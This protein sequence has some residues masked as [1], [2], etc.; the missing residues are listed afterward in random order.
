MLS[1]GCLER[2]END[3]EKNEEFTRWIVIFVC[4]SCANIVI[5][6][7]CLDGNDDTVRHWVNIALTYLPGCKIWLGV[8]EDQM[9][10]SLQIAN[11]ECIR[12]RKYITVQNKAK[13]CS[14]TAKRVYKEEIS[15]DGKSWYKGWW[16]SS[17]RD[18]YGEAKFPSGGSYKGEWRDGA[19]EGCG[20]RKYASGKI[21]YGVFENGK[22]VKPMPK[23]IVLLKLQKKKNDL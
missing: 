21:E 10:Q 3:I 2:S 15:P 6:S 8:T 13:E 20:I 23:G 14:E 18:G 5:D 12:L 7:N 22:L 9:E 4:I 16:K 19:P 11:Y 17:L 1:I